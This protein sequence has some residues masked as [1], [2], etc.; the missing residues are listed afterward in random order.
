VNK[1]H[2]NTIVLDGGIPP[3][4][5]YEWIDISYDLVVGGLKKSEVKKLKD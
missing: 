2:W 1:K 3:K 5:L 4:K